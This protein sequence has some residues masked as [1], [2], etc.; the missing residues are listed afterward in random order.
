M[1]R[2]KFKVAV[3]TPF[4]HKRMAQLEGHIIVGVVEMHGFSFAAH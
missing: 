4:L 1:T 3:P 2:L